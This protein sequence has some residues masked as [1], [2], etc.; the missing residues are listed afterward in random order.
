MK[1]DFEKRTIEIAANFTNNFRESED[2]GPDD[3]GDDSDG[4][5]HLKEVNNWTR[6]RPVKSKRR[7]K[8]K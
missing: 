2:S 5:A 8:K 4:V 1:S 6:K 7:N 3:D